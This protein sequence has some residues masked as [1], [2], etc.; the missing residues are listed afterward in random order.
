[1]VT[2]EVCGCWMNNLCSNY[3]GIPFIISGH[4]HLLVTTLIFPHILYD[5]EDM[6]CRIDNTCYQLHF[7]TGVNKASLRSFLLSYGLTYGQETITI[8]Y[9]MYNVYLCI[10]P[11]TLAH[12][13]VRWVYPLVVFVAIYKPKLTNIVYGTTVSLNC[14]V[15]VCAVFWDN[16]R[17]CNHYR[18]Y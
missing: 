7:N 9:F 1:M 13:C 4:I 18:R 14:S 11:C 3:R 17:R 8:E 5:W 6:C 2:L 10:E 15:S 16:E 12:H